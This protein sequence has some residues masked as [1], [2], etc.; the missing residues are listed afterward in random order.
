MKPGTLE[1]QMKGFWS[2][3]AGMKPGT[4]KCSDEGSF[5]LSDHFENS[6]E[7]VSSRCASVLISGPS[8]RHEAGDVE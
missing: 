5:Y 3:P 6:V 1:S 7:A 2:V 4:L 8:R